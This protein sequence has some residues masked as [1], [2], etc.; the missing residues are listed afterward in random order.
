MTKKLRV[1]VIGAGEFAQVCHVP[2]INSHTLAEVVALC[3]RQYDHV[4]AMANRLGIPDVHTNY[5]DLCERSDIDAVTIATPNV[6]HAEQAIAAF[7]RGKHVFCEKPLGM[8]VA[9]AR[10][11]LHAGEDSGK[12]HQVGF[13]FRYGYGVRELRRRVR[14]GDL[15]EPHYLRIQYDGWNGLMPDWKA[16][17]REKLDLAGGGMLYDLGSHLFDIARFILG[18]IETVTGFHYNL[19]RQ[20]ADCRTGLPTEV[21]TDDIAAAWFRHESGT[22][23]QWLISRATPSQTENGY[24]EVIGVE[25]ALKASLSRG[26]I[27]MLKVS[28][29]DR[30]EWEELP[31][32][33]AAQ[34]GKPHCLEIMMQSFV[35]ACLHGKLDGDTDASFYDGLAVQEAL[36]AVSEANDHFVWVRLLYR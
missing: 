14:N 16:G 9:E 33:K 17:W 8:T 2:G 21:Q 1:G 24:L 12:V 13:T 28:R 5:R 11:M 22:R 4:R 23:G 15:G 25:G 18:P 7:S 36:A 27:D 31:L 19:P 34:D 29:P 32:P 20:R 6:D 10:E 3:G 26:S 30:P 35:N